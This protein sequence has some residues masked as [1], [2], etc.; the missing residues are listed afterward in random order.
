MKFLNKKDIQVCFNII[1]DNLDDERNDK[2][3]KYEKES[4]GLIRLVDILDRSKFEYYQEFY[5]KMTFLLI[6]INK[7]HFFS[8]GN[9][10]VA[11]VCS[12]LFAIKN[13]YKFV[14]YYDKKDYRNILEDLFPSYKKIIDY[15]IFT[16][17]D[18]IFF[19]LQLVIADNA[20]Y[21]ISMDDIRIKTK[22]ILETII[23]K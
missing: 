18:F 14:E 6:G 9:K 2:A 3:P 23:V 13:G 22:I 16:P 20:K 11:L 17:L 5:D 7:G 12:L 10:R 15:N 19:N 8:N 21:N 4:E 1:Y